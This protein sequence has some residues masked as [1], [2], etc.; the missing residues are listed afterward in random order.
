MNEVT[1]ISAL[2]A[3][4]DLRGNDKAE[5]LEALSKMDYIASDPVRGGFAKLDADKLKSL[6][7]RQQNIIRDLQEPYGMFCLP[8]SVLTGTNHAQ[9]LTDANICFLS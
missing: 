2:D 8:L 9:M 1:I 7:Y 3:R 4:K 5:I 6:S